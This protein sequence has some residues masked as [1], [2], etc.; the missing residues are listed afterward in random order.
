M[1]RCP[2][3]HEHGGTEEIDGGVRMVSCTRLTSYLVD[4]RS[5]F[6][7][8]GTPAYNDVP[9]GRLWLP[10]PTLAARALLDM[11]EVSPS[12]VSKEPYSV[13]RRNSIWHL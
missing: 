3:G 4:R 6:P 8:F 12:L 11:K 10:R 13:F 7:M 1:L 9:L 2:L 5:Y